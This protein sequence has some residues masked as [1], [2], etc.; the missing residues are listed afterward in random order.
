MGGWGG[1]AVVIVAIVAIVG[2]EEATVTAK[3]SNTH[4]ERALW[5]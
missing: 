2:G 4:V 3:G 5:S 1:R